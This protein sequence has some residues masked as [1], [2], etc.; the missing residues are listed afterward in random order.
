MKACL[1][2]HVGNSRDNQEDNALCGGFFPDVATLKAHAKSRTPLC[3]ETALPSSDAALFAVS[4]GMGGHAC[5][6]VA[7]YLTVKY[8]SD[9]QDRLK[10]LSPD[11]L[12]EEIATLN[13]SVVSIA[14]SNPSCKGM[15]ATLCGLLIKP[16]GCLG[17]NVGDS[18]AYCSCDGV[19]TQLSKDQ[20]EGQRLLDLGLLS[21]EELKKFPNRKG[22]CRYIGIAS[23]LI[24]DVF[25]VPSGKRGTVFLLCSDGLSDVLSAADIQ[26]V[27]CQ[28]IPLRK[29]GEGLLNRALTKNE[30]HGDNITILLIE[31]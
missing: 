1:I 14:R 12:G 30:G 13:D 7:S 23:H 28:S 9:H 31:F 5:G 22:L 8:L 15:G 6:E 4:D 18:R 10:T 17:F 24:P 3:Y 11:L 2:S 26:S 29:K 25:P 20:T 27:L 16:D 21:P 19:L